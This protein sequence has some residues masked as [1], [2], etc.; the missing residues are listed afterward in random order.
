[1][2]NQQEKFYG[3]LNTA[4]EII[5]HLF[6]IIVILALVMA[7]LNSASFLEALIW[8]LIIVLVVYFFNKN[9][10]KKK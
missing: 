5:G 6:L 4:L 9:R 2:V 7:I 8:I 10:K 3:R 1:M